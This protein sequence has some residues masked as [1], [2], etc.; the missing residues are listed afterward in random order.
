MVTLVDPERRWPKFQR[1]FDSRERFENVVGKRFG[2][3]W[4]PDRDAPA[5][6]LDINVR[7]VLDSVGSNGY[8]R[9]LRNYARRL[10]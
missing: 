3:R 10:G 2:V 9:T 7:E 4:T 5:T 1:S 8:P 6:M